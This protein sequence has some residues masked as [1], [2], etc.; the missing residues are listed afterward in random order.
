MRKVTAGS[1]WSCGCV[2]LGVPRYLGAA[3]VDPAS[4]K[5]KAQRSILVV[6]KFV[7]EDGRVRHIMENQRPYTGGYYFFEDV[8]LCAGPWTLKLEAREAGA[9]GTN[10]P[11]ILFCRHQIQVGNLWIWGEGWCRQS[12]AA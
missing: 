12:S 10:A 7:D 9:H 3:F 1:P 5:I 11:A 8:K 2:L 4:G 6:L